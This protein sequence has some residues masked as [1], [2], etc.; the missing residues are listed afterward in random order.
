LEQ[1]ETVLF[2]LYNEGGQLL[3]AE[4]PEL[5][6]GTQTIQL[7][8]SQRVL[9]EGIYFLRISDSIGEIKINRV[10]KV[11]S[12]NNRIINQ[13]DFKNHLDLSFFLFKNPFQ[14]IIYNPSRLIFNIKNQCIIWRLKSLKLRR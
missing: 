7:N 3:Y 13:C 9:P 14:N 2:H 12:Y 8:L 10:V 1:P 11:N 6:A 4:T 5:T